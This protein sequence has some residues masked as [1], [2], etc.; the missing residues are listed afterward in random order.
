M[1]AGDASFDHHNETDPIANDS[2]TAPPIETEF[3]EPRQ[4][5]PQ[6]FNVRTD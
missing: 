3:Y 4:K 5:S 6:R 2:I 1:W